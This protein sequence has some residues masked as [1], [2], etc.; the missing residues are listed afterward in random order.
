[1]RLVQEGMRAA[2]T[3]G[4][5]WKAN[6]VDIAVAGK[7][8]TAEFFGPRKGGRLPTHAWFTAYA[9]YDK[10]EI[11][12][13]VFVYSGGEG[14]EVAAPIATD[15]LRAYFKPAQTNFSGRVTEVTDNV[16]VENPVFVGNVSNSAGQ[17]V[18]GITVL[19]DAGD[20]AVVAS[21][22]TGADGSF[23]FDNVNYRASPRWF[24]RLTG[25]NSTAVAVDVSA[26]KQY[27]VQFSGS[28]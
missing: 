23:R 25:A 22:V 28:P 7:T 8:G 4:T 26:F 16:A 15:I 13:V 12:V 20:G 21:A 17:G 18:P 9:P 6:L 1:M 2:V 27:R 24:V 3:R 10:P 14:S 5:S 11:A 19:L